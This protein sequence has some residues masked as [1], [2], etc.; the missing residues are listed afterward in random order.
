METFTKEKLLEDLKV[1]FAYLDD[2]HATALK[3]YN[4]IINSQNK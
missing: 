3:V 1:K 4:L 2:N